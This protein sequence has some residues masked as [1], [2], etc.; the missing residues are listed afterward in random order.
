[1]KRIST[2]TPRSI[3]KP[4]SIGVNRNTSASAVYKNPKA[5]KT[6]RLAEGSSKKN[7][8]AALAAKRHAE[9]NFVSGMKKPDIVN[10]QE[11]TNKALMPYVDKKNNGNN[12]STHHD[13]TNLDPEMKE[14]VSKYFFENKNNA[15]HI[16]VDPNNPLFMAFRKVALKESADSPLT[17][18]AVKKFSDFLHKAELELGKKFAIISSIDSKYEN[19][20]V[21]RPQN[22]IADQMSASEY[23]Q[24]VW[25]MT[26]EERVLFEIFSQEYVQNH[27]SLFANGS[28]SNMDFSS[29]S[30]FV[31]NATTVG[32]AGEKGGRWVQPKATIDKAFQHQ[33]ENPHL[34]LAEVL[35]KKLGWEEGSLNNTI[36]LAM[37]D[38]HTSVDDLQMPTREHLGAN[39][40]FF[41]SGHTHG[42][43]E[44]EAIAPVIE[45][46]KL[47]I[48]VWGLPDDHPLHPY[49]AKP[50]NYLEVEKFL[51][52]EIEVENIKK[53]M[54][55]PLQELKPNDL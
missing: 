9:S 32:R 50:G 54:H 12:Q 18:Q 1:M 5:S 31:K 48:G 2:S 3:S 17:M 42:T 15:L 6:N 29:Y 23:L 33:K 53:S 51:S 45:K 13:F 26:D 36:L 40:F 14:R 30:R 35:T 39:K 22:P 19:A 25:E 38:H 27:L 4:R 37:I 20:G 24:T 11:E 34:S 10:V 8:S 44:R 46:N 55:R 7:S 49:N 52:S 47:A 43:L 21:F 16:L 41:D 28:V